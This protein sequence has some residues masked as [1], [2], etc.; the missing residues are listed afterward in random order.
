LISLIAAILVDP[1][2]NLGGGTGMDRRDCAMPTIR[3]AAASDA[4]EVGSIL[5][6]GFHNDPVMSWVFGGDDEQRARKLLTCFTFMSAEANIPLQ[7]TFLVDGGCACWTPLPGTDEWPR[8]RGKR[9][10]E[11]LGAECDEGDFERL[12]VMGI[13]MERA[14]PSEPHWYLG[15]IAAVRSLQG[16]GV[17]TGLLAHSLAI[18]DAD[19]A[20]AYLESSNP[21][22]VSLYER[23]GFVVTGRIDLPG[24]PPLIP[25]WRAATR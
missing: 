20:P 15:S 10:N 18:V 21:R 4:A 17:G 25:M 3:T 19:G 22:N 7:A 24:G 5:A 14:H 6:D 2:A 9:F 12:A 11:V 23:H 13:A 8:E 1:R 16:Q